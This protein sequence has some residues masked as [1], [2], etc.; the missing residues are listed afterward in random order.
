MAYTLVLGSYAEYAAV[1][2][3]KLVKIPAGVSEREAAAAILQGM[4]AHYLA[5]DTY[6]AEER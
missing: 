1:P 3:D 6:P 4:T 5:Y 2:A